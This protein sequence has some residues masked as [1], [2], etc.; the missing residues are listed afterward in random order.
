[1]SIGSW[2]D[3]DSMSGWTVVWLVVTAVATWPAARYGRLVHLVHLPNGRVLFEP[4]VNHASSSGNRSEIEVRTTAL[5][6]V[7]GLR[8]TLLGAARHTSGVRSDPR[9]ISSGS[10]AAPRSRRAPPRLARATR[11]D[12]RRVRRRA[13]HVRGAPRRRAHREPDL[14]PAAT[15]VHTPPEL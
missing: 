1:M 6:H 15:T 8:D 5:D 13:R 4:L 9:P 14:S 10:R 12:V 7:D 11:R 3:F 2:I